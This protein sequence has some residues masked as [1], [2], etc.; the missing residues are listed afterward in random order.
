MAPGYPRPVEEHPNEAPIREAFAAFASGAARALPD[1]FSDDVVWHVAGRSPVA[2]DYRGAEEIFGHL[3]DLKERSGGTATTE[4][5]DIMAN[6]RHAVALAHSSAT[7]NG[8]S[9]GTVHFYVFPFREGGIT[10]FWTHPLDQYAEDE[11]WSS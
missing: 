11:F 4:L 7:R 1:L 8:N 2:G 10:E 5:H 6:D 9:Y 3:D